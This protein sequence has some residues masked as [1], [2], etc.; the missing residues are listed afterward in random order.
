MTK[1]SEGK[2]HCTSVPESQELIK[3][4]SSKVQ[5]NLSRDAAVAAG[6]LS[7]A[8]N[9]FDSAIKLRPICACHSSQVSLIARRD[10]STARRNMD[11]LVPKF[12][13]LA[14]AFRCGVCR[15]SRFLRV[16]VKHSCHLPRPPP[17]LSS[18]VL[19]LTPNKDE[20]W[21]K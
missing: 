8:A 3:S 10:V 17:K 21:G 5:P 1:A 13:P 7:P 2:Q 14:A 19:R 6:N 20:R 16:A 11:Y 12:E 9:F 18:D 15:F 4:G